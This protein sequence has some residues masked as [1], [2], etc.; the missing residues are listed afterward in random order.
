MPEI[1]LHV[2]LVVTLI[3]AI[4]ARDLSAVAELSCQHSNIIVHESW[5]KCA[6]THASGGRVDIGLK[7]QAIVL[8]YSKWRIPH[9][10]DSPQ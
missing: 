7:Y 5:S 3:F 9:P 10:C 1:S 8:H 4:I 6:C 2:G